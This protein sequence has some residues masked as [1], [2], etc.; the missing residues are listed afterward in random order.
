MLP[1]DSI[2]PYKKLV[3]HM[4]KI[5]YS[6]LKNSAALLQ[7]ALFCYMVALLNPTLPVPLATVQ[8]LH[9]SA[10]SSLLLGRD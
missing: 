3:I 10:F 8:D 4:P 5:A 9:H 2:D 7:A 6:L 1:K